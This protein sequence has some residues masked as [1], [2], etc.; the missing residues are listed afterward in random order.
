MPLFIRVRKIRVTDETGKK[1]AP[2]I[3]GA[4]RQEDVMVGAHLA[5]SPGAFRNAS[6]AL[7]AG[8]IS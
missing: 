6:I 4:L 3:P 5:S 1:I 7:D 8:T 2:I